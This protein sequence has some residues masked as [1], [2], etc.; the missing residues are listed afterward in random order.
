MG[1]AIGA[2]LGFIISIM[3][4]IIPPLLAMFI[5]GMLGFLLE[6]VYWARDQ[7]A[8][9]TKRL[10]DTI[11]LLDKMINSGSAN[12]VKTIDSHETTVKS[13]K[14]SPPLPSEQ[15]TAK[16]TLEPVN[17]LTRAHHSTALT[18]QKT[19]PDEKFTR[20]NS[21]LEDGNTAMAQATMS[22]QEPLAIRQST[23]QQETH[24]THPDSPIQESLSS[25][26]SQSAPDTLVQ[27]VVKFF[28]GE[29]AV[30]HVGI[31]ILFLG[32][33]F[34]L[35]YA[36]EH[37]VF[38]LWLRLI[39]VSV[40]AIALLSLGWKLKSKR[41][42]YALALQ[43]AGIGILYLD[44][45]WA[46]KRTELLP[47][48]AAFAL[49]VAVCVF[50]S[51][52][53]I[54]QNSKSLAIMGAIGGFLAPILAS[55]NSGNYPLLFSFYLLLNSGILYI[56][57][58]KSWRSLNMVGFVFTFG[59]SILWGIRK[60]QPEMFINIEL[61]LLGFFIQYLIISIL[62]A[63]KQNESNKGYVDTT[64][65]FGTPLIL[66]TLQT[67]LIKTLPSPIEFGLAFSSLG[68]AAIYIMVSFVF[69]KTRNIQYKLF[70][71]ATLAIG[72][73]FATLTIPLALEDGL[74]TSAI[75][76][77]EGCALL[78]I[79]IR[80]DRRVARYF[81]VILQFLAGASFI[82]HA[83]NL[84]ALFMEAFNYYLPMHQAIRLDSD[85]PLI[86]SF[87]T[88]CL[89]IVIAG[90][91]SAYLLT[92]N[93]DK[94]TNREHKLSPL[95]LVWALIWWFAA[96]NL[97]IN[98]FAYAT[99]HFYY[100]FLVILISAVGFYFLGQKLKWSNLQSVHGLVAPSIVLMMVISL[101]S[102]NGMTR[103]HPL[104]DKGLIIWPMSFALFYIMTYFRDKHL[105]QNDS[106]NAPPLPHT[107]VYLSLLTILAVEILWQVKMHLG[108][109][110]NSE[111]W[112]YVS[113][114]LS[115]TLFMS[116]T[117]ALSKRITWPFQQH[118]KAYLQ[119]TLGIVASILFLWIGASSFAI[120]ADPSP[121]PYVPLLNPIELTQI[122]A[123]FTLVIWLYTLS[124]HKLLDVDK[125]I[126][127]KVPIIASILL[128][129]WFNSLIV[130]TLG[131][132]AGIGFSFESMTGSSLAQATF[133]I[134]WSL[135]ALISM[136]YAT[137]KSIRGI[138]FGGT[139]ILA[140]VVAKLFLVDLS[141]I[142]TIA[143]IISFLGVGILLLFIG[144]YS[145]LP[146]ALD[147]EVK[148]TNLAND[149]MNN[150][151]T[152]EDLNNKDVQ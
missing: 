75:W 21:N 106:H 1:I 108:S 129:L 36:A 56:A 152:T 128:F 28:T 10:E 104:A 7:V 65:V 94:V 26:H 150:A 63:T 124:E 23:V 11:A 44:I 71:E 62:F 13:N 38:P 132:W 72:V 92:Q 111:T 61:F 134:V 69:S 107:A 103:I 88:G 98:A 118:Q 83:L 74:W 77:L 110:W 79:G 138:W 146:P 136:F 53:A 35:K 84:S 148:N 78:W 126:K 87:Y 96:A 115:L 43:G 133:S 37:S 117:M 30:V 140:L 64:L 39:G 55:T 86:N 42:N 142:G 147:T 34:L 6:H 130:R 47:S 9:L 76:A 20:I 81:G 17:S 93:Q 3:I 66:F 91:L 144:Y 8:Q 73:L 112:V 58:Y 48:S 45:V 139:L 32:I 90:L 151:T 145:P 116:I 27:H 121:L 46:L 102:N 82:I 12:S 113:V 15:A 97:E 5:G 2:L 95:L 16:E 67:Y 51:I 49:L 18:T 131:H 59:I 125:N 89:I 105:A 54:A 29:N 41:M 101:L 141:G 99:N 68:L 119:N 25:A 22:A 50:S 4:E 100:K 85:L 149:N 40:G 52:L 57:W 114:G 123:M 60:Y 14:P 80:Q 137:R 70:S 135:L 122:F 127:T 31:V 143:R 19:N 109:A 33:A 24:S 120:T